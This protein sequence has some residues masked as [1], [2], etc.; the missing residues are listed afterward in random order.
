MRLA[1]RIEKLE[2]KTIRRSSGC[3]VCKGIQSIKMMILNEE[4]EEQTVSSL[5]CGHCGAP[6]L[7]VYIL[8]ALYLV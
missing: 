7:Q 8:K 5:P 6:D 1:H 4:A 3:G 2:E